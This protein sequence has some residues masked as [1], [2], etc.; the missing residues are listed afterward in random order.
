[1]PKRDTSTS[2]ITNWGSKRNL[3]KLNKMSRRFAKRN[4]LKKMNRTAYLV[5]LVGDDYAKAMRDD[6]DKMLA[7]LNE[8]PHATP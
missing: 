5:S 1:M 6:A 7:D 2:T 4:G 3:E 8:V